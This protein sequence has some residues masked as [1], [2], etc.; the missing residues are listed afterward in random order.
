MPTSFEQERQEK[1]NRL[2][3]WAKENNIDFKDH[4]SYDKIEE[5]AR[6]FYIYNSPRT[7]KSYVYAVLELLEK[8][9]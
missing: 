9:Y 2:F 6:E 3:A 4:L 7:I 8:G 5:Q 1:I